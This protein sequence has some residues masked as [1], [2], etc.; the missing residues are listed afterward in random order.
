MIDV[1]AYTPNPSAITFH[2]AHE[3]VKALAGPVGSGKSSAAMWEFFM[4]CQEATV[5]IRGLVVRETYR[6][7][8]DTTKRTWNDWFERCS[9]YVKQDEMA[10]L[11]IP[12]A[13]GVMRTHTMDFRH[14]RRAADAQ[15]FMSAE[16]AFIWFEECVPAIDIGSGVVGGGLP[17]ELLNIALMRQRQRGAHRVNIV[18]TF[19][20]PSRFHWVYKRFYKPEPVQLVAQGFGLFEQPA[21]ENAANLPSKYYE[22]LTAQLSPELA[23]RFVEGKPITL[24]PG[25]RVYPQVLEHVHFRDELMPIPQAGLVTFHDFGRTPC[26]II[27]QVLP[28]GR[29]LCLQELQLWD[30]SVETMATRLSEV[31][32]DDFPGLKRGR[33]WGDPSGQYAHETDDK[34]AFS[35]MAAK[36]LSLLPGAETFMA[37]R[38]AVIQRS[39]RMVDGE[40]ALLISRQGCPMLSE[41]LLGG[42]RYPKSADGQIGSR[43]I[44]NDFSHLAN[45]LE[46]GL[47]GEF[48]IT[49]GRGREHDPLGEFKLPRADP[50]AR[51]RRAGGSWVSN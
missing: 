5:P 36:G 42:Y 39:E 25:V 41:A 22:K 10:Q 31:L 3:Q 51:D 28:N 17:E 19:N 8:S 44:K 4:L 16:Y 6:Q 32:K 2:E 7:L 33:G 35:V 26:A 29:V 46:Y 14:A 47:T 40:P 43:P 13:D 23:Q 27:A 24:Y 48:S 49:E 20:P 34:T 1:V 50:L 11:T 37:R 18:L 9:T 21:R 38:E 30:A 45:A 15:A 12:G